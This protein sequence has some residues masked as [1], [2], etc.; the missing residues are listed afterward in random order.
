[1]LYAPDW[2]FFKNK[3]KE[4]PRILDKKIKLC[5]LWYL[6]HAMTSLFDDFTIDCPSDP[7]LAVNAPTLHRFFYKIHSYRGKFLRK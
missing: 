6:K 7:K 5:Q 4:Q 2:N 1:M 3:V